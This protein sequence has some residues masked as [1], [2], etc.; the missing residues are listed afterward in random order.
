MTHDDDPEITLGRAPATIHECDDGQAYRVLEALKAWGSREC[1]RRD[2]SP[3]T[4]DLNRREVVA[5]RERRRELN[6][7]G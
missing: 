2:L 3:R 4:F 6:L 7:V 1:L 5:D